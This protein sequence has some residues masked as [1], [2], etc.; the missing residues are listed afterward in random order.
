MT[1]EADETPQVVTCLEG[2]GTLESGGARMEIVAG[3]TLVVP[4]VA[5]TATFQATST[6][7]LLR[8]WV[9]NLLVAEWYLSTRLQRLAPAGA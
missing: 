4:A 9:P 3:G 8:S 5:G 7:V 6:A 1:F 2:G